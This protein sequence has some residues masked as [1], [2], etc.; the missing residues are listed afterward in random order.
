MSPK[1]PK[2]SDV[3]AK[4]EEMGFLGHI[5]GSSKN[6]TIKQ[7]MPFRREYRTLQELKW[8]Q[9]PESQDERVGWV[10][11]RAGTLGHISHVED[12]GRD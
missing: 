12:S 1:T 6:C 2:G 10:G 7:K 4:E 3:W 9:V 11:G 5:G 8:G